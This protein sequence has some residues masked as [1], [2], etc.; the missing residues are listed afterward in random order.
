[1]TSGIEIAQAVGGHQNAPGDVQRNPPRKSGDS[2]AL[3][4]GIG[5]A[6]ASMGGRQTE[7]EAREMLEKLLGVFSGDGEL[8]GHSYEWIP[9]SRV[10]SPP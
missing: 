7:S 1:M 6:H 10:C 3:Q 5:A 2:E 4:H 8:S 9:P